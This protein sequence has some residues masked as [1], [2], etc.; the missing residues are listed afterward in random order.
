[1]RRPDD[2]DLR[3]PGDRDG[4]ALLLGGVLSW[5]RVGLSNGWCAG[6]KQDEGGE[7]E[8]PEGGGSEIITDTGHVGLLLELGRSR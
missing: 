2:R 5:R 7:N 3:L 6:R 8:G 1:M 4:S